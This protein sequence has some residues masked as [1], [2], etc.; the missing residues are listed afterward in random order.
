MK[1]IKNKLA[2]IT[3]SKDRS[4][5]SFAS[6]LGLD[7]S[8]LIHPTSSSSSSSSSS[9]WSIIFKSK[10]SPNVCRYQHDKERASLTC[11]AALAILDDISTYTFFLD[12][13]TSRPGVSV[14]LTTELCQPCYA[15]EDVHIRVK[16]DKIGKTLGFC[17]FDI[18]NANDNTTVYAKGSHIKFLDMGK[19]WDFLFGYFFNYTLTLIDMFKLNDPKSVAS[20]YINKLIGLKKNDIKDNRIQSSHVGALFDNLKIMENAN[21][22]FQL[23]PEPFMNNPI[24]TLHGGALACFIEHSNY[25]Y[26]NGKLQDNTY[27][28]KMETKYLSRGKGVL[29]IRDI[30]LDVDRYESTGKIVNEKDSSSIVQFHCYFN[31]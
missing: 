9:S 14:Y 12:D 27:I 23:K 18:V 5:K 28:R 31:K 1:R 30:A 16:T 26:T 10:I 7:S 21:N 4:K 2:I 13:L 20:G 6:E 3:L 24:G 19:A 17:S 25:Q 15:N 29:L 22:I 8:L 11:G